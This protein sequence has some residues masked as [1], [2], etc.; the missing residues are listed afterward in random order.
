MLVALIFQNQTVIN[1]LPLDDCVGKVD[2]IFIYLLIYPSGLTKRCE[3]ELPWRFY[4][5]DEIFVFRIK[6]KC[7]VSMP[8]LSSLERV[9]RFSHPQLKLNRGYVLKEAQ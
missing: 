4:G 5:F 3:N 8:S 1:G 9:T 6:I 7:L 2:L